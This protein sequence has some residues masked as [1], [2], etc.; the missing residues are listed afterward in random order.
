MTTASN[1]QNSETPTSV[2]EANAMLADAS[3]EFSEKVTAEYN[4]ILKPLLVEQSG[5]TGDFD[6]NVEYSMTLDDN[7]DAMELNSSDAVV[8][9]DFKNPM[10]AEHDAFAFADELIKRELVKKLMEQV[11]SHMNKGR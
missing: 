9:L 5:Y 8:S 1:A 10:P 2:A 11:V 6:I 4:Q 7:G 3:V